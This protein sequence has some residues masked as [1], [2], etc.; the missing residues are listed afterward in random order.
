M[1]HNN[2]K[3]IGET[4]SP[5]KLLL[6]D[7]GR[8][9]SIIKNSLAASIY[10]KYFNLNVYVITDFLKDSWQRKI[11]ESFGIKNFMSYTQNTHYGNAL[12]PSFL[13]LYSIK[14]L[15]LLL[16]LRVIYFLYSPFICKL[17]TFD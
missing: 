9:D 6:A 14:D 17:N 8:V 5:D 1:I 15:I 3:I 16:P 12:Y 10:N 11:Y 7:R 13:V 2:N 4:S